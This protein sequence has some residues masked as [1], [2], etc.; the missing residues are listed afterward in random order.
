VIEELSSFV[1]DV[2]CDTIVVLKDGEVDTSEKERDEDEDNTF[3]N[4]GKVDC[5]SFDFAVN[6]IDEL[7]TVA[8]GIDDVTI[9][10]VNEKL[11][12]AEV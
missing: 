6:V 10:V 3:V 8:I 7:V 1:I 12:E 2:D 9:V 4:E 5:V 11:D